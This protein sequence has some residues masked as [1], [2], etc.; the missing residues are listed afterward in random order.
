MY[1]EDYNWILA[2]TTVCLTLPM[3]K[4]GVR[5]CCTDNCCLWNTNLRA[6]CSIYC[7]VSPPT[8]QGYRKLPLHSAIWND[9]H[10]H[11]RWMNFVNKIVS[12][13]LYLLDQMFKW[14]FKNWHFSTN[15][16]LDVNTQWDTLILRIKVSGCVRP[17][18]NSF[19]CPE[20][21]MTNAAWNQRMN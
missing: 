14:V 16:L 10:G 3:Q 9:Y 15:R 1:C 11:E 17:I 12:N 20:L 4:G 18:F 8:Q 2:V 5:T 21:E 19:L 13:V 7:A 6:V